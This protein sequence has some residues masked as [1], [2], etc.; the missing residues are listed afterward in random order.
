MYGTLD[1]HIAIRDNGPKR[2]DEATQE[3]TQV[4]QALRVAIEKHENRKTEEIIEQ[5][6]E[7][8]PKHNMGNKEKTQNRQ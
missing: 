5:P 7:N 8:Q 4:Q 6:T 3:Y 2:N 1:A